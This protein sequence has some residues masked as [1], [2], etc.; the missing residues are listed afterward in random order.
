[1]NAPSAEARLASLDAFR[2]ATVAGMLLVNNP[3]SWSAIYAPLRHA[4]WHGW[5]FTDTIFPF[6]LW[7][8][9]V[10]I[11]IAFARRLAEGAKRTGLFRHVLLRAGIIFALGLLLNTSGALLDGSLWRDGPGQWLRDWFGGVRIM[12]VLQRIALCYL[13]ASAIYLTTRLRGRILWTVALLLG[14][15]L[16]LCWVP[17]PGGEAGVFDERRNLSQ[18]LDQVVLGAHCYHGT[19]F[20]DPEGLLS[21]LPAI[22]TCLLGVLAGEWLRAARPPAERVAWLMVAGNVLLFVGAVWDLAFPINKKIWTSSYA[23]FMAGL[24]ANCFGVWYW[25]IDA[26]GWRGWARPFVAFGMNALAMFVLAGLIGRALVEFRLPGVEG[27]GP[28]LKAWLWQTLFLPPTRGDAAWWS[29]EFAS[30]L[31]ALGFV[32]VFFLIAWVMYRRK[33]FIKV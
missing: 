16:L 4:E 27:A 19:K 13:A 12:G 24:A 20:Y 1:M 11:P 7:I 18:W 22:A 10:A 9:G 29:V 26:Q 33:W 6:F 17:V 5:T 28:T 23:V 3:G 21:T 25:L 15:W 2:G 8:V 31:Y 32:A 30:L 14:Y